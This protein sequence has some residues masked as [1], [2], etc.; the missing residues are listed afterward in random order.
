MSKQAENLI[1]DLLLSAEI[2]VDGP[3]PWDIQVHDSRFYDR[4]LREVALG[5]G[6]S[7]MDGWWDCEAIDQMID[8]VL[9]ARLDRK[10]GLSALAYRLNRKRDWCE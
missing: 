2:K 4:V 9:R 6:E 8:R 1:K 10:I 3:D 5:L 7:Y